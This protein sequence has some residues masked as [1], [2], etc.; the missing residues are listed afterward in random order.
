LGNAASMASV[1]LEIVPTPGLG[2]QAY[3]LASDGDA[4][5]VDPPRD[6]WRIVAAA[7]QRG[8]RLRHVRKTHV[9]NDYLSGALELRRSHGVKLAG[10]TRIFVAD[11][12]RSIPRL[13]R[14]GT[15]TVMC[16]AGARASIVASLLDAA[17]IPVRLVA[18]GGVP[19]APT[20]EL[21]PADRA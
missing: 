12:P 3:L 11:L 2:N 19:S 14:S 7:E 1:Q 21:V 20:S 10:S 4:L 18:S 15:W 17:G 6:A 13:D 9:H 5:V 8:W 16:R